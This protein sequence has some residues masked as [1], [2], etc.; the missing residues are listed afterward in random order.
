LFLFSSQPQSQTSEICTRRLVA[1]CIRRNLS[2]PR[3]SSLVETEKSLRPA[4]SWISGFF[5]ERFTGQTAG[6]VRCQGHR[7]R[8]G[9]E[10]TPSA[11]AA[12]SSFDPES[13]QRA[14][15]GGNRP[16]LWPAPIS[17]R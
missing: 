2:V 5:V 17:R 14:C 1:A 11:F 3:N 4:V 13:A 10:R 15:P 16:T 9:V 7:V 6:Q 8:S 12:A